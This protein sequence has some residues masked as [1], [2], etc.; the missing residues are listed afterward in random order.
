MNI[1]RQEQDDFAIE[2]YKRSQAA[3]EKGLFKK[4][5]VPVTV[6]AKKGM[7]SSVDRTD[8]S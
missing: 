5:I 8:L 6:K 4:E 3:G 2:S 1:S 7:Y